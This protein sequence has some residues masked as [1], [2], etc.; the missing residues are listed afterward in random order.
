MAQT[1]QMKEILKRMEEGTEK[2]YARYESLIQASNS[3][4]D[5]AMRDL[6]TEH[7]REANAVSARAK[8]DL[9]NTLEKMAESGYIHSGETVQ[10]TIAANSDRARALSDLAMQKAKDKRGYESQKAQKAAELGLA[11][12]KEIAQYQDQMQTELREQENFEREQLATEKQRNFENEIA[13]E[14]LDLEKQGL[15][16]QKEGQ[17]AQIEIEKAQIENQKIQREI[18]RAEKEREQAQK[19]SEQAQKAIA[20]KQKDEKIKP[21]KSPYEYVDEIVKKYTTYNKKKGYKEIDRKAIL[22]AIANI[23]TDQSLNYQY[24]YE[25]YLYGKSLG[26]IKD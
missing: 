19:A 16:V 4:Y 24:R 12:Q 5:A 9:K 21:E 13:R 20:Q 23:V 10:A 18:E 25:M 26:Y 8:V 15:E 3:G 1:D 2:I 17:K 7:A 14:K 6:E 22:V 11:A